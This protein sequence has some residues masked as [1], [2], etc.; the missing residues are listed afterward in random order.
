MSLPYGSKFIQQQA[1]ASRPHV[2]GFATARTTEDDTLVE[3]WNGGTATARRITAD[4]DGRWR[5]GDGTAA[6]P[7]LGFLADPDTGMYR[8]GAN[9]VGVAVGGGLVLGIDAD[10]IMVDGAV[11]ATTLAGNGAA[12]TALDADELATGEIPADRY[13]LNT[14]LLNRL[15]QVTGPAALA[16]SS[17]TGSVSAIGASA[18]GQVLKRASGALT[19]AAV[20]Y[21]ELAGTLPSH[22]QAHTTLT[23][24]GLTS[25]HVWQATGAT[26]A[27]FGALAVTNT[28]GELPTNRLAAGTF[29][30]GTFV[31][32]ATS[33]VVLPVGTDLYA[34]A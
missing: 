30:A 3:V 22:T 9:A 17:G 8:A 29:G 1:A 11:V 4:K 31:F 24:T 18:D 27:S 34:T 20:N 21:T 14:I 33:R 15:E 23:Y 7:S 25:G 6:K 26:A 10:G 13:A 32:G 16:R 12:L 19:F 5:V 28:T 2:F